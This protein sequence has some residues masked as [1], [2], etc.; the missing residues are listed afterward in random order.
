MHNQK[1]VLN[2]QIIL[3][4]YRGGSPNPSNPSIPNSECFTAVVLYIDQNNNI[5]IL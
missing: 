1:I 5:S 3:K 2:I 4:S